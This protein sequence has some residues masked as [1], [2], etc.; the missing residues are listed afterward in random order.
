MTNILFDVQE[1]LNSD[2]MRTHA[3]GTYIYLGK[4][5]FDWTYAEVRKLNP[6][7][8]EIAHGLR[9]KSNFGE[10][11]LSSRE[12]GDVVPAEKPEPH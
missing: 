5:L 2:L 3:D 10:F 7:M 6:K 4:E 11:V 1:I 12:R 8:P 9:V